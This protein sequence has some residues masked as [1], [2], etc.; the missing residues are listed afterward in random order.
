MIVLNIGCAL[1]VYLD[2]KVC[3]FPLW[4]CE[5]FPLELPEGHPFPNQKYPI[6]E[7]ILHEGGFAGHIRRC[8]KINR[9]LLQLVHSPRYV[10]DVFSFSLSL[11]ETRKV[12]FPVGEGYLN[13]ALA[14]VEGTLCATKEILL[15]GKTIAGVLAGGTH[16]AFADHGEGYCT[17]NDVAVCSKYALNHS[18][19]R[20]LVVDLDAHQGNGTASIFAQEPRVFTFS[21]H[22]EENYPR[23]KEK[24]S[25]DVG[26]PT[27]IND[28]EYLFLLTENL[29]M[30]LDYFHPDLVFYQSGVDILA[31]DR[32]GRLGLTLAGLKERDKFVF[33]NLLKRKIPC[34]ITLGGGY[35]KDHASVARA[36]AQTFYTA[37]EI[38]GEQNH[39]QR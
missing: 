25:L 32:F 21:M 30:I 6:L 12:G 23:K 37:A 8:G 2:S 36:H 15:N 13:R 24:S 33:K 19:N 20:I 34:V 28:E 39:A 5:D 22:A 9:E 10:N 17:F 4:S 7:K 18:V 16:H 26:L 31:A 27:G 14:S 29:P 11:E 35:Q 1:E 3:F 38:L